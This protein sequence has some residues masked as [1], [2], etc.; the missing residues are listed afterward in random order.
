MGIFHYECMIL[1]ASPPQNVGCERCLMIPRV[2]DGEPSF[3]VNPDV[4]FNSSKSKL[5]YFGLAGCKPTIS[6]VNFVGT[7]IE[8]VPYKNILVM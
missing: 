6:L 8:L 1:A 4:L 7:T 5:I 3:P 2:G